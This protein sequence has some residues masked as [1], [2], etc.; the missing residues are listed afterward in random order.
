MKIFS[1]VHLDKTGTLTG[2]KKTI[3]AALEHGATSLLLFINSGHTFDLNELPPLLS[4]LPVPAYA[5]VFPG[6]IHQFKHYSKGSLVCGITAPLQAT[7]I[8]EITRPYG[9]INQEIEQWL[10]HTKPAGAI[11]LI[12]GQGKGI[13]NFVSC[14]YDC[15]G[16][17]PT[18][19]GGGAGYLDFIHRPCLITAEKCYKNAALIIST[20]AS[21]TLEVRHGWEEI[22]GPFLVTEAKDNRLE[23]INFE[24]ALS[25]YKEIIRQNSI[26]PVNFNNFIEVSQSYP[27]GMAQLNNEFLVR[28]PI[29]VHGESIECAGSI[30]VNSMIYILNSQPEKLIKSA[31]K[32]A[33][34]LRANL[35]PVYGKEEGYYTFTIDCISRQLFLGAD[36][37]RELEAIKDELPEKTSTIGIL[38]IGEIASSSQGVIR[39]LNKTTLIGGKAR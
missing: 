27:L 3:D 13:D 30:P 34:N 20:P 2:L 35:S 15:L 7:I 18:V 24:P 26:G 1:S 16:P 32:A 17:K 36:Y 11:V 12:D 21:F 38:S 22:A 28:D 6:I 37:A 4:S 8:E 19:L 10:T 23:S 31:R 14:L 25:F 39:F 9:A 29:Q 5:G 33:R